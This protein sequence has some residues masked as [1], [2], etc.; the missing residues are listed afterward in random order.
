MGGGVCVYDVGGEAWGLP[1]DSMRVASC[2][3]QAGKDCESHRDFCFLL[4]LSWAAFPCGD[5][6][7]AISC[8]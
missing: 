6:D 3:L 1:E 5:T 2:K 4:A 7:P 8:S